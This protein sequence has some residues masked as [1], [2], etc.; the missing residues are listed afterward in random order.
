MWLFN[1]FGN[2]QNSPQMQTFNQMMS[3][4]TYDQQMQTIFNMAKSKGIDVNAKIFT[5][6][7]TRQLGLNMKSLKR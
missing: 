7:E 3:G 5:E 4:K 2:M 1:N 6:E